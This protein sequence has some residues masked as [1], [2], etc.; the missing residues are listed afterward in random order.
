MKKVLKWIGIILGTMFVLLIVAAVGLMLA[1]N[2]RINRTYAIE[3]EKVTIPTDEDELARGAHLVNVFCRDCHGSDLGG[4]AMLEDPMLGT[5]YATNI[6][7]VAES[8][9][10]E[11]LVIAIRHGMD[12]NGRHLM[13]MPSDFFVHFSEDDLGAIIA[14]LKALPTI[15]GETT[16]Q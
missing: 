9:S 16:C 14:Y 5:I 4:Q 10:E 6:T 1:G 7:G 15:G 11:D 3:A 8:H 13:M 12:A 2:A